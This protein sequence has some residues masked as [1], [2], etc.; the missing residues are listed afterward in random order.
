MGFTPL[1]GLVMQTRAGDLDPGLALF[2]QRHIDLDSD[3]L[4][5]LLERGSGLRGL[6]GKTGDYAELEAHARMGDARAAF[7]LEV[8]AYR[9]RKYLGAYVAVLGGVDV[10]VFAGGIGE[11]S[12]GARSAIVGPLGASFGWRLDS[13]ANE[14]GPGERQVSPPGA[15][16]GIWVIPTRETLTIAREARALLDGFAPSTG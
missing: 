10:L 4:D 14:D 11:H 15:A 2:L 3:E 9:I 7:T 6:S 16:P 1:E 12:A 5:R 8:F 13:A